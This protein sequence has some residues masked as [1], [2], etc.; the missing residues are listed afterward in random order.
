MYVCMY[1]CVYVIANTGARTTLAQFDEHYDEL[2]H[3]SNLSNMIGACVVAA[4]F[5]HGMAVH[6]S[7]S[8]HV[9]CFLASVRLA[10]RMPTVDALMG[11]CNG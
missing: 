6:D 11:C 8:L 1:L 2:L 5:S 4:T 3:L 9:A 10:R 7:V